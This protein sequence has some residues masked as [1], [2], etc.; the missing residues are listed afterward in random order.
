VALARALALKP[1]VLMLDNP[2]A[3]LD[4]P[5][6]RWWRNFLR[7]LAAGHPALGG[8]PITIVAACADA[9]PWLDLGTRFALLD[10]PRWV[11]FGSRREFEA[12]AQALLAEMLAP[13]D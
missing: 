6:V 12:A 9:R 11:E 8:K 4:P 1:E 10:R 5:H 3:G 7:E 13:T 2:L